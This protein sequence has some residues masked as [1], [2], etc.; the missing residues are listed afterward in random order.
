MLRDARMSSVKLY[1]GPYA[2]AYAVDA[3]R[4]DQPIEMLDKMHHYSLEWLLRGAEQSLLDGL[5]FARDVERLKQDDGQRLHLFGRLDT[6]HQLLT[7]GELVLRLGGALSAEDQRTLEEAVAQGDGSSGLRHLLALHSRSS[8]LELGYGEACARSLQARR[9]ASAAAAA[10]GMTR[11]AQLEALEARPESLVKFF[12][13]VQPA[14]LLDVLR[15]PGIYIARVDGELKI[16]VATNGAQARVQSQG[17]V[18]THVVI[19]LFFASLRGKGAG[20]ECDTTGCVTW[21]VEALEA[22]CTIMCGGLLLGSAMY[23]SPKTLMGRGCAQSSA[24]IAALR[25]LA[26]RLGAAWLYH[27]CREVKERA[28]QAVATSDE[29]AAQ[30]EAAEAQHEL[31]ALA[32]AAVVEG[33][34]VVAAAA[35]AA[36]QAAQ[37]EVTQAAAA[38]ERAA[39]QVQAVKAQVEQAQ[40]KGY[41]GAMSSRDEVHQ[42]WAM[43]PGVLPPGVQSICIKANG[44]G[45]CGKSQNAVRWIDDSEGR[46]HFVITDHGLESRRCGSFRPCLLEGDKWRVLSK[47]ELLQVSHTTAGKWMKAQ[48]GSSGGC[49][50]AAARAKAAGIELPTTPP[51][52]RAKTSDGS[53]KSRAAAKKR[54]QQFQKERSARLRRAEKKTE[55][56]T[57][58]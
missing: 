32:V 27:E 26:A 37:E 34:G 51:G 7:M 39:L 54:L 48:P 5:T 40:A 28:E 33:G 57:V 11:E 23:G 52:L 58:G 8:R 49:V 12:D 53:P 4:G 31:L 44:Q 3:T 55:K 10:A 47:D 13:Q 25:A 17:K 21:I 50:A 46:T 1:Q 30:L 41:A 38:V 35:E 29:A 6:A 43:A 9:T 18:T 22:L 20:G 36:V 56:E 2:Q 42:T 19:A 45:G 15:S 24:R 14:V 16:G